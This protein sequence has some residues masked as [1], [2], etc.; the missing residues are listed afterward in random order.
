VGKQKKN[1]WLLKRTELRKVKE[2][3]RIMKILV[4]RPYSS[5]W[6]IGMEQMKKTQEIFRNLIFKEKARKFNNP[7]GPLKYLCMENESVVA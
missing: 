6:C 2:H 4:W 7:P 5:V 3:Q 1:L